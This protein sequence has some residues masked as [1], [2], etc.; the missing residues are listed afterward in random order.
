[1]RGAWVACCVAVCVFAHAVR[2]DE[3]AL[4]DIRVPTADNAARA[5]LASMQHSE[6]LQAFL[7]AIVEDAKK[8]DKSLRHQ[9]L[10]IALI[11]LDAKGGPR[12]AHVNGE[13]KVYPASVVKF[14]YLMAAYAW[15][16]QNRLEIDSAFDRQ[17]TAMIYRSS[18]TATR[19]VMARLTETEPGP[20]LPPGEYQTFVERRMAVKRWLISLGIDDLHTVHPTYNGPDLFGRD[21]QFLNDESIEGGIRRNG[22]SFLNR[23]SMTALGTAELLALLAR[24]LAMSPEGSREVR[25]RMKR[26][27]AKQPYL[28]RRIA[29]GAMKTKGVE[30]YSKTGT[31]GPI[32]ADAGIVRSQDGRDLIVAV[33]LEGRPAYRGSFVAEISRK[34]TD[35]VLGRPPAPRELGAKGRGAGLQP[36]G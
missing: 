8:R 34:S 22:S 20:R 2:A 5:Y 25:R 23:Q 14:V 26:D 16:E 12:F 9:K 36:G 7:D 11:D 19:N 30:V 10:H 1:M 18:N 28:H 17:L 29:G 27:P 15:K 4:V 24:D 33:Y 35:H 32:Y 21:V 31:W 3:G 6:S 13:D